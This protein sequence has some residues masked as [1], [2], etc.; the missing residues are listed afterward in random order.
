MSPVSLCLPL[1]FRF[2]TE[3]E[4]SLSV[5]PGRVVIAFAVIV[6][7]CVLLV[8]CLIFSSEMCLAFLLLL[9]LLLLVFSCCLFL[10]CCC[11]LLFCLFCTKM[12]S[13][14]ENLSAKSG[15]AANHFLAH[16][17]V[18]MY[19]TE[20]ESDRTFTRLFF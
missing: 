16:A 17:L 20:R 6:R 11:L 14:R 19:V 4:D 13:K 10:F 7:T 9:L 1:D 2:S 18:L 5:L 8:F 12:I 3:P 15:R